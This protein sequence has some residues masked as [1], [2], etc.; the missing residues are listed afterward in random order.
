MQSLI[1]KHGNII[2]WHANPSYYD[3]IHAIQMNFTYDDAGS[4]ELTDGG[5]QTI[6]GKYKGSFL[7]ISTTNT[8]TL[9]L[10]FKEKV[11]LYLE[12]IDQMYLT[13]QVGFKLK[14]KQYE[15]FDGYNKY[16]SEYVLELDSSPFDFTSLKSDRKLTNYNNLS[17]D[18]FPL[19]FY[20]GLRVLANE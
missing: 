1:N 19:V 5:S 9:W 3:Y 8:N 15:H 4:F 7:I 18:E 2:V 12:T 13:K 17:L 6:T 10:S 11:N 20:S 14:E 16:S